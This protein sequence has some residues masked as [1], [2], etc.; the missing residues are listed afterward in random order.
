MLGSVLN[1]T[2]MLGSSSTLCDIKFPPEEV[3]IEE[4]TLG[5]I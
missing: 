1:D 2:I 4:F 5:P 3:K